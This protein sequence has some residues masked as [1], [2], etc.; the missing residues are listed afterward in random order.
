MPIQII[1]THCQSKSH[2]PGEDHIVVTQ[3]YAAVLDGV[4]C[5][6]NHRILGKTPGEMA[7]EIIKHTIQLLPAKSTCDA[8]IKHIN[9]AIRKF[10][11]ASHLNE[12]V[13]QHPEKRIAAS[14]AIYSEYHQE[15]WLV[16]DCQCRC[17]GQNYS[18]VKKADRLLAEMRAFILESKLLAGEINLEDLCSND[19]GREAI[20]PFLSY[21]FV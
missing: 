13:A 18:P 4:T 2:Q 8:A 1:E 7:V 21:N 5:K 10:Y 6:T 16:G 20:L 11:R 3:A 19:P 14:A 9:Q 17:D 15:I 12:E